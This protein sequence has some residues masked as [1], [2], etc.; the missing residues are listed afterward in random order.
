MFEI[1]VICLLGDTFCDNWRRASQNV[2]S[3]STFGGSNWPFELIKKKF[4]SIFFKI[5][6]FIFQDKKKT[7]YKHIMSQP[8]V[9]DAPFSGG[10]FFFDVFSSE[11]KTELKIIMSRPCALFP[12]GFSSSWTCPA[13][14]YWN[15]NKSCTILIIHA[16]LCPCRNNNRPISVFH[17]YLHFHIDETDLKLYSQWWPILHQLRVFF[18]NILVSTAVRLHKYD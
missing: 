13:T 3:G 6:R 18:L 11:K 12:T 16:C 17:S 2:S 1:L 10:V 9:Q 4:V 14:A 5:K 8:C 7:K 15:C